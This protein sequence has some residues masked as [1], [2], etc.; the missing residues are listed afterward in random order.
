MRFGKEKRVQKKK[1]LP[2]RYKSLSDKE[3]SIF[4]NLWLISFLV[5]NGIF[6][7]KGSWDGGNAVISIF[8]SAI[9]GFILMVIVISIKNFRK[10]PNSFKKPRYDDAEDAEFE[11]ID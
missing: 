7:L 1:K 8:L 5:L 9:M 10:R 11:D 3:F 4:K 2:K 6:I